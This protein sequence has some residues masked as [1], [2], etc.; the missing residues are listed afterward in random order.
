[1]DGRIDRVRCKEGK[2]RCDVCQNSDAMIEEAEALQQA[3][4]AEEDE[5]EKDEQKNRGYRP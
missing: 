2:E 4:Q 5:Q 1:M 3:Y